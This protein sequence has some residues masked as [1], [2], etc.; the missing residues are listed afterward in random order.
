MDKKVL[1]IGLVLLIIAIVLFFITASGVKEMSKEKL[2]SFLYN[3]LISLLGA[4]SVFLIY[5][6]LLEYPLQLFISFQ[7][8]FFLL[9][10]GF[11]FILYRVLYWTKEQNFW[12]ELLFL[13]S[14]S[15]MNIS[16]FFLFYSFL[17]DNQYNFLYITAT[18]FFLLPFFVFH[19]FEKGILIPRKRIRTWECPSDLEVPNPS[20]YELQKPFVVSFFMKKTSNDRKAKNY[21]V[22]APREM[23]FGK[24]M[25]YFIKEYNQRNSEY[26][27][28]YLH[29]NSNNAQEWIFFFKP[30]WYFPFVRYIDPELTVLENRLKEKSVIVCKRVEY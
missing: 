13:L 14:G 24:L 29:R 27:I 5:S 23:P 16:F 20:K 7:A 18:F 22:I 25:F 21:T 9:G 28:Q 11:C 19:T 3:L 15:L 1:I 30:R 10:I 12:Y 8:V 4:S 26:P 2:K 17:A 6:G